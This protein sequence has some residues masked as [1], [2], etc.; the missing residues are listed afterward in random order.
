MSPH[1]G[2]Y[3]PHVGCYAISW[4]AALGQIL[5]VKMSAKAELS[6]PIDKFWNQNATPYGDSAEWF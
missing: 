5:Y 6:T 1:V 2:C 3:A 4:N